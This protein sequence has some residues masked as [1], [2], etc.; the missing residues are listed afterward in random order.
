MSG[1]DGLLVD[2][3]ALDPVLVVHLRVE[4]VLPA[5]LRVESP[6]VD[7]TPHLVRVQLVGAPVFVPVSHIRVVH[8]IEQ[9]VARLE[10]EF[11]V[12]IVPVGVPQQRKAIVR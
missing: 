8:A 10:T 12:K 1:L 2:V 4:A 7:G 5:L 11:S 3:D 6:E 9:G